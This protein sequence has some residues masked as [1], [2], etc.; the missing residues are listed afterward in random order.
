MASSYEIAR[1]LI[2]R[3]Q[4]LVE[5]LHTKSCRLRHDFLDL[6]H[7]AFKY[8]VGNEWRVQH[9]FHRRN[10]ADA[11]FAWNQIAVRQ[12]PWYSSDRSISNWARRSS[13]KKLIILSSAWLAL[14]ACK[15]AR[16]KV[17]RFGKLDAVFHGLTIT[18]F[19]N[20]DD[21]WRLAQACSSAL[22]ARFRCP[23]QLLVA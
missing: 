2:Q 20:Q 16:H 22:R 19:A 23:R 3:K 5:G 1:I 9:D 21:I 11:G 7:L 14:L 13:G 8:Q 18:D 4:C 12:T 10:P 15:V 17:A 6:A